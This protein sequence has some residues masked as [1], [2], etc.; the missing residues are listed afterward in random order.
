MTRADVHDSDYTEIGKL[1]GNKGDQNYDVPADGRL[2]LEMPVHRD[3]LT[4]HSRSYSA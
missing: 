2:S 1:K 4:P 3:L